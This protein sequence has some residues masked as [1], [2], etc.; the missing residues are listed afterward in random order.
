MTT[1]QTLICKYN[2]VRIEGMC[3]FMNLNHI[4]RVEGKAFVKMN[5][6]FVELQHTTTPIFQT[7]HTLKEL[8]SNAKK[9]YSSCSC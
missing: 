6:I 3:R 7:L 5:G 4:I 8:M 9:T 1:N 2:V